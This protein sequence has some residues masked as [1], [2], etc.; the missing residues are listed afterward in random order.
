MGSAI[1]LGVIGAGNIAREHL[2]VLKAL[3]DVA[4]A[5][6]CSRTAAKAQQ[7]A[8]DFGIP[9]VADDPGQL[10]ETVGVDGLLVLV[11]ADQVYDVAASVLGFGKPVFLE[12]PPGLS[13]AETLELAELAEGRGTATMVG[14][15]R[16]YYTN[17]RR[18]LEIVKRHG[19]LLGILVEGHERFAQAR[20]AV[21]H[22]EE[23]L[24]SWLYAN[25]T[26]TIDLL[27]FFGGEI[28][29]MHA[30]ARGYEEKGGDQ[31][32]STILFESGAIGTYI[33]HWLSPG[34][35]RVVLYGEGVTVEFKPLEQGVWVDAKYETHSL[36][37]GEKDEMYKPGF[38]GQMEAFCELVRNGTSEWPLQDLNGAYCTM[39]L[40]SRM[41]PKDEVA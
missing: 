22:R 21:F 25:A 14:F 41:A 18:G 39:Q 7:L 2:K 10:I 35:W 5:G 34:G 8:A 31:F 9:H 12:K 36:G 28:E 26:H 38:Y 24:S 6:I 19:A 4:V 11:S 1:R 33:S 30:F 37:N 27:R 3:D 40:A 15:N 29:E 23:V 17:F 13:P 16:R 32:S 20:G